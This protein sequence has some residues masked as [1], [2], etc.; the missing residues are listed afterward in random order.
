MLRLT[1]VAAAAAVAGAPFLFPV[2]AAAQ[3]AQAAATINGPAVV[4]QIRK[5]L[6]DNYVL[7]DVRPKLDSALAKGL[8]EGRYNLS[9]PHLLAARLNQD[10][11]AVAHDKHLNVKFN[12]AVAAKLASAP[13]ITDGQDSPPSAEDIH[14]ATL[15]NHGV[16]QLKVLAGNV[17]YI[18]YDGFD[19]FG[20]KSAEAIDQAMRFLH[21]GDAVIIDLRANGGG[22]AEAVRYMIS[23]FLP[24]DR[25]L[26]TF[27]FRNEAPDHVSTL[28]SLPTGRMVGKPL[29]VLTS[30]TT[31]SAAEEFTGHVAGFR[32]GDVVGATTA[33]G[34]FNNQFFPLPD[35]MVISISVGRAVLASTGRDWEGVGIAPTAKIEPAKALDLAHSMA[36][37]RLAASAPA[38]ERPALLLGAS[39]IDARL[40]PVAQP[41]PLGAYSG[42]YG[43]RTI[44][45]EGDQ[46][47]Y[48]RL[49]GPK[50][51]LIGV[52]PNE[53][54]VEEDPQTRLL[55][56]V[57]GSTVTGFDLLRG[58][59]SRVTAS[60]AP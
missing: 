3:P 6:A 36:L 14:A 52:G 26:I 34:G 10:L 2:A 28:A 31:M 33:G 41:L 49:N 9:D 43:E 51:S 42:S 29:Y 57:A 32:I 37:K 24:A 22:N 44:S 47:S 25:P 38:A 50:Y 60:R 18:K 11:F 19:W 48:Q 13:Q 53:F 46:L 21:D 8:T 15:R 55:F 5:L 35:G 30:G 56:R 58:D 45:I 12:P 27:Y 20:P 40:N 1:S 4:A 39:L 23:H 16:Q 17:R 7:L 54:T 59:G